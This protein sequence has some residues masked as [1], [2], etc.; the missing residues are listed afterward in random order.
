[1]LS[2]NQRVPEMGFDVFHGGEIKKARLSDYKGKWLVM[3][4]Y[5]ADF[6]F[7][8]PTELTEAAGM[9]GE[10]KKSGAEILSVS[11]D[12]AFVHKAWHEN[13]PLIK[14][15]GYAMAADP[16]GR[17]CRAFGT[18]IEAEGLST[19]ATFIIDPDGVVKSI[20]MHDNSIGR[21]STETLRKLQAAKFVRE[22]DGHLCPAS[23][24]PG[25]ETIRL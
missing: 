4:F 15:V 17:M 21:S 12:T 2:V 6:T 14:K 25:V 16:G 13:S 9:Y 7:V 11:T 1:M 10:F 24:K 22:N 3:L 19:R 18:Y 5:P 8:C 20:E 23:W